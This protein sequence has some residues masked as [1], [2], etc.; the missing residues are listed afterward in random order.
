MENIKVVLI[1]QARIGSSRLPKKVLMNIKGKTLLQIH[2]E[3]ASRAKL[4]DHFIVATTDEIDSQLICDQAI[5]SGWSFFQG[6]L[7]DVLTRFYDS[8]K[9]IEPTWI[10]RLTSDC[11]F[12]QPSIIDMMIDTAI[13]G[14]YDYVS[15]SENFPDG[16]DVEVFK[17]KMLESAY[18]LANVNSEREH[19]TPWIR[20]NALKKF[21]VEPEI[22]HYSNVRLTVDE[23]ADFH[24]AEI[25]VDQIGFSE[26]WMKY[27]QYIESN[28]EKF[29]NQSIIRNE[30]YLKSLENDKK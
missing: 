5:N 8:V 3:N 7:N 27:S 14:N 25:L 20:K 16:V 2:L 4:V 13:T 15:T 9:L 17:F 12:V 28:L 19:V 30:G 24:C 10:V 11:P 26:N 18:N 1:T 21:T 22:T 6:S 23:I 29:N